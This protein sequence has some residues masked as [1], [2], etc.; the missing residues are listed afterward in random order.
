MS[1]GNAGSRDMPAGIAGDDRSS[2]G[3][4]GA[5]ART[6]AVIALSPQLTMLVARPSPLSPCKERLT[7]S[8]DILI[9]QDQAGFHLLHGYLHLAMALND[10]GRTAIDVPEFG[11]VLVART[12]DGLMV[13]TE[14][15]HLPLLSN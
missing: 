14:G 10:S 4:R 11:T 13:E 6:Q 15:R 1:R 3:P 5:G 8:P 9:I 12:A 2:A 7:M